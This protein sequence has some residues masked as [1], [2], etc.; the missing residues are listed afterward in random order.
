MIDSLS[1][2]GAR[3][4]ASRRRKGAAFVLF[5]L[6]AL[7]FAGSV[8]LAVDGGYLYFQRQSLQVAAD[9][10]ALAGALHLDEGSDSEDDA[11]DV[12]A[13]KLGLKGDAQAA[14]S[15]PCEV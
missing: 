12:L 11:L 3:S 6:G 13:E 4:V 2:R 9:A 14:H 8:G 15:W 5:G 1:T 10:A 7:T